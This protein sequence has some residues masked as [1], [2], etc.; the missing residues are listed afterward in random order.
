M[1][2]DQIKNVCS[3]SLEMGINILKNLYEIKKKKSHLTLNAITNKKSML[4]YN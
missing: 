1:D 2:T 3:D 4:G